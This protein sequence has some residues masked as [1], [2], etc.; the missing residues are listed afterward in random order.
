MDFKA[1]NESM[2]STD[3]YKDKDGIIYHVDITQ[4]DT[5]LKFNFDFTI[6]H[7]FS[8]P[9]YTKTDE[10]ADCYDEDAREKV[11]DHKCS[12]EEERVKEKLLTPGL[13]I[14]MK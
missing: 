5:N 8:H 7:N 14:G 11:W 13:G 1:A 12:T 9:Y 4:N 2:V 10:V 6:Y 3:I